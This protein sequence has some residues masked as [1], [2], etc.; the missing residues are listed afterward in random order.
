MASQVVA[1]CDA[2]RYVSGHLL[3]ETFAPNLKDEMFFK[4]RPFSMNCIFL[5]VIYGVEDEFV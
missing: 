3:D 2:V 4:K 5:T 1:T